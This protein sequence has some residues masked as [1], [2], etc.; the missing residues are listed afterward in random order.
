MKNDFGYPNPGFG[1]PDLGFGHPN[2]GFG[3][4]N[5]RLGRPNLGF[6]RPNPGLGCPNPDLDLDIHGIHGYP[7]NPAPGKVITFPRPPERRQDHHLPGFIACL[8]IH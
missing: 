6:G 2:P 4:S 1:R 5:P 3:R 8:Q 7:W